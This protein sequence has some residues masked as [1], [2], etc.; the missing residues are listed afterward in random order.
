[1]TVAQR[2]VG[3]SDRLTTANQLATARLEQVR[4]LPWTAVVPGG[5]LP[6]P[7]GGAEQTVKGTK[8]TI[9]TATSWIGDCYNGSGGVRD[10]DFA[11]Y[12]VTV[13]WSVAGKSS[14]VRAATVRTP[15]RGEKDIVTAAAVPSGCS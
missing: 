15:L 5:S 1:M 13:A 7:V 6:A 2:S 9:T 11:S 12:D 10:Q 14:T 8:Y 4:Q 3:G